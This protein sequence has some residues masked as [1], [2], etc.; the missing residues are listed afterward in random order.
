[1][2]CAYTVR[3]SYLDC[4]RVHVSQARP[5]LLEPAPELRL[6]VQQ[7]VRAVPALFLALNS[8]AVCTVSEGAAADDS[9]SLGTSCKA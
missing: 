7:A 9:S 8:F 5:D 4:S 6:W 3:E 2:T 1:M